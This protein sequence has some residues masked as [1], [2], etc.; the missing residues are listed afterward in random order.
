MCLS[1]QD[2]QDNCSRQHG[3]RDPSK[4]LA[5]AEKF[6]H[7]QVYVLGEGV[8]KEEGS[9]RL[10]GAQGDWMGEGVIMLPRS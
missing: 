10:E 9:G 2:C 3:R 6:K 5:D 8:R 4:T 1:Y 7:L